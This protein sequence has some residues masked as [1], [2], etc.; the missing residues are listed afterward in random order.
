MPG[1]ES[2]YCL[3]EARAGVNA[4]RALIEMIDAARSGV[5]AS[6]ALIEMIDAARS[7][8]RAGRARPKM[9]FRPAE[10]VAQQ[11]LPRS[12][13]PQ[14]LWAPCPNETA[15]ESPCKK[16]P[17]ASG[18]VLTRGRMARLGWGMNAR[19]YSRHDERQTD[20]SAIK[21]NRPS[22]RPTAVLLSLGD[23]APFEW[24]C[25]IKNRMDGAREA[26]DFIKRRLIEVSQSSFEDFIDQEADR[27]AIN[28]ALGIGA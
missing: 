1:S 26:A 28:R 17:H 2:G 15:A 13:A 8:A 9:H 5:N 4:S 19:Q 27:S 12:L 14:R 20:C 24:E 18:E 3:K 7:I 21:T 16:K 10:R 25:A 22:S 11:I 6:R 23:V